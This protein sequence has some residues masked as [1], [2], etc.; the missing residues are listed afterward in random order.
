MEMITPHETTLP[1]MTETR[2]QLFRI[3]AHSNKYITQSLFN[4]TMHHTDQN[5]AGATFT[6][7]GNAIAAF[8]TTSP[9]H[10]TYSVQ[11]DGGIPTVL[12]GTSP[13]LREQSLLYYAGGLAKGTHAV[14]FLDI[15]EKGMAF[16]L[17]RLVVSQWGEW[18]LSSQSS[19]SSTTGSSSK[20]ST[21]VIIGATVAATITFVLLFVGLKLF[22]RRTVAGRPRMVLSS[23]VAKRS[24]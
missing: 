11:L 16:D 10:G 17:D 24:F 1:L 14:T 8:G 23:L 7:E 20:R 4:G 2:H 9:A 15:D 5:N 18:D 12:N 3:L 21:V 19:S 6:F 22:R 13:E